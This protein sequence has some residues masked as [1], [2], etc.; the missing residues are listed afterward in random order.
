MGVKC[1]ARMVTRDTLYSGLWAV[2]RAV[3]SQGALCCV[4]VV[5]QCYI[6]SKGSELTLQH[7]H[8]TSRLPAVSPQLVILADFR[9]TVESERFLAPCIHNSH[10]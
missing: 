3:V 5:A 10:H 2:V 6:P 7:G 4:Q 8:R 9:H 1:N